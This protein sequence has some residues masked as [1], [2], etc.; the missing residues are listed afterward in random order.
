[1][2][3]WRANFY[4]VTLIDPKSGISTFADSYLTGTNASEI[5]GGEMR[6]SSHWRQ[7]RVR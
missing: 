5:H 3:F 2:S 4:W 6:R 7:M 1:M